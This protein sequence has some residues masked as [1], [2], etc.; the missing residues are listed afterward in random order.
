MTNTFSL[1]GPG[2]SRSSQTKL[3]VVLYQ[4]CTCPV[5]WSLRFLLLLPWVLTCFHTCL[6]SPLPSPLSPPLSPLSF[7]LP[8]PLSP[9][10]SPL[11]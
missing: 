9:P 7:P 6:L 2:L 5:A 8:S 11:P 3:Y 1:A 4:Y 10:V